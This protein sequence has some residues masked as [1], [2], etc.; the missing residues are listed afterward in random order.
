M[1]SEGFATCVSPRGSSRVSVELTF[2]DGCFLPFEFQY[3][4]APEVLVVRPSTAGH[5]RIRSHP[6]AV[7]P[8]AAAAAFTLVLFQRRL[9][10]P[11]SDRTQTCT[12]YSMIEQ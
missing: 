7:E 2:A 10:R 6:H 11:T 1:L 12:G 5:T 8:A 9:S 3:F 4:N